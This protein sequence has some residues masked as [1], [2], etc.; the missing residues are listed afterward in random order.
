MRALG[1]D[2]KLWNNPA[3]GHKSEQE[4]RKANKPANFKLLALN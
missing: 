3:G 4:M 2:P 1:V